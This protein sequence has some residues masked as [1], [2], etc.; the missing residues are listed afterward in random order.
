MLTSFFSNMQFNSSHYLYMNPAFYCEG[1]EGKQTEAYACDH[2]AFCTISKTKIYVAEPTPVT[3]ELHLY[4]DQRT[5]DRIFIQSANGIGN[6]MGTIFVAMISDRFGRGFCF[7]FALI[8]LTISCISKHK[9][10]QSNS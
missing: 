6:W 8:F 9:N 5:N 7:I 1:V 4:C 2:L 10:N 3:A